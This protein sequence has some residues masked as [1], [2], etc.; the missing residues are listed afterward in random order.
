MKPTSFVLAV[1]AVT[2]A[3]TGL[4][5]IVNRQELAY[6]GES[7]DSVVSR[8]FCERRR[9]LCRIGR[10]VPKVNLGRIGNRDLQKVVRPVR[11][12]EGGGALFHSLMLV[13]SNL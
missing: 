8:T 5:W 3:A 10:V 7:N 9:D 12:L 2:M 1:L 4:G 6:G 13:F 11:I